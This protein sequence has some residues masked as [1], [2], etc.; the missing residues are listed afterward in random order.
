MGPPM[1]GTT[2]QGARGQGWRYALKHVCCVALA[3]I[4]TYSTYMLTVHTYIHSLIHTYIH[5]YI[6]IYKHTNIHT[7]IHTYIKIYKHTNI[8]TCMHGSLVFVCFEFFFFGWHRIS[9]VT[10]IQDWPADPEMDAGKRRA[11]RIITI[12]SFF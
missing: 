7:Y 5:T 12:E 10:R 3:F 2:I 8:H 1:M 9:N 4:H 11:Y 6:K